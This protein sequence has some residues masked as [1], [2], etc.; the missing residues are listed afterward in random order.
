[1]DSETPSRGIEARRQQRQSGR[2]DNFVDGAFA[3]AITLLVISGASLPHTVDAL[4]DALRGVPAFAACFAQLAWLWHGHV[5]WRETLGGTDMPSLLLSLLL[6]FFAL[7]FVFPLYLVY[8]SFFYGF[9]GGM[10]SPGFVPMPGDLHAQRLTLL[11][12]CYGLTYACMAGT[13]AILYA[14]G[15]RT[16]T[17]LS[18]KEDVDMRMQVVMWAYVALIGLVSMLL[19]LLVPGQWGISLAGFSY[20]LL[21]FTGVVVS[22]GYRHYRQH[23]PA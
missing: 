18:G 9:T 1:M 14:H 5:R 21:A 6:V 7:I 15:V 4:I 16:A 22:L 2:L 11:F 20:V 23:P 3:F 19:A 13:L 12:A 10:L 17:W 8:S